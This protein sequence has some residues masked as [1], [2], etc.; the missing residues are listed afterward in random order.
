MKALLALALVALV[1]IPLQSMAQNPD[2]PFGGVALDLF[3]GTSIQGEWWDK[4]SSEQH[5]E[6]A[7]LED[8]VFGAGLIFPMNDRATVFISAGRSELAR[9]FW[10]TDR[11]EW[12]RK[13]RQTA[14][15]G[16]LRVRFYIGG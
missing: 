7:D 15:Y 5:A 1:L 14:W 16:E 2:V 13:D 10:N 9:T 3:G 4:M 8:R 6:K 12:L 11:D